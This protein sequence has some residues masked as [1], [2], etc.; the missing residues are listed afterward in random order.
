MG[1]EIKYEIT[2]KILTFLKKIYTYIH[3]LCL[4]T[5]HVVERHVDCKFFLLDPL[6]L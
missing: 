5:I 6:D 3:S 1:G 2:N 4:S